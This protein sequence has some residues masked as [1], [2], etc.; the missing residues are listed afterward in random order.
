MIRW[1]FD[2]IFNCF[3]GFF[4]FSDN[5]VIINDAA[6]DAANVD[7]ND[8]ANDAK[9]SRWTSINALALLCWI[10]NCNKIVENVRFGFFLSEIDLL[11]MIAG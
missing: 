4:G 10:H 7:A 1:N 8:A 5:F 2:E 3:F 9:K 6:S 11:M